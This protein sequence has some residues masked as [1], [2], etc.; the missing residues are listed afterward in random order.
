MIGGVQIYNGFMNLRS[1]CY[2]SRESRVCTAL[3]LIQRTRSLGI[4]DEHE[5]RSQVETKS[6]HEIGHE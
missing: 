4:L 5:R 2:Y 1:R 6:L 3:I